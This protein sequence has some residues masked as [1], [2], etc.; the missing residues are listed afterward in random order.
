MNPI[1]SIASHIYNLT[2]R[3]HACRKHLIHSNE[4]MVKYSIKA[5]SSAGFVEPHLSISSY[6]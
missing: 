3:M 1:I 6:I 4:I 2:L 5:V